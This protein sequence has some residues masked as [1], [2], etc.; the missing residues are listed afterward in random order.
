M[1]RD[2]TIRVVSLTGQVG[3]ARRIGEG[4]FSLADYLPGTYMIV[5]TTETGVQARLI[6]K[7]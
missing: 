7:Q 1:L 2:A 5:V 6:I 4:S 3:E